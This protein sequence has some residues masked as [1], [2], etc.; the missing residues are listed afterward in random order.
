M[1]KATYRRQIR[2]T[3]SKK[4]NSRG[5]YF[6][7]AIYLLFCILSG[8]INLAYAVT[9]D[10]LSVATAFTAIGM[11]RNVTTAGIYHFNL[12][13]QT[14]TSF[15]NANGEVLVAIE[16]GASSGALTQTN[17][18]TNTISGA[19][20]AAALPEFLG[21]TEIRIFSS[22]GNIDVTSSNGILLNRITSYQTL[23][24]G[25]SDNGIN[26]SWSGLGSG[27]LTGNATCTSPQPNILNNAIFH[28]CGNGSQLHWLSNNNRL[29]EVFTQGEIPNSESFQLF[30]GA[31]LVPLILSMNVEK[32]ANFTT[33]VS[34]GQVITYT[35]TITN[36]GGQTISN[37]SLTDV[38][39]GFGIAPV[40]DIETAILTDNEIL[41][42]SFDTTSGN[43]EWGQLGY[44]DVLTVTAFY[45]VTQE[46]ID[47]L[48]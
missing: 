37:V 43:N 14:F 18:L 10:G 29:R 36:N 5:S 39:D 44:A 41:G 25:V 11:A 8:H 3:F 45:T 31:D 46:D 32:T 6:N 23:H 38:H 7:K 13:G 20:P 42:D 22:T 33:N 1:S 30:V 19:L 40:P 24:R 17:A 2:N 28:P 27:N 16:F 34:V 21:L 15:V 4:I 12:N 26:N 48:Q 9:R 47:N 35:Y